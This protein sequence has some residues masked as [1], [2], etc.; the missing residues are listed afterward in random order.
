M[1][2]PIGYTLGPVF[3][4]TTH[5][6]PKPVMRLTTEQRWSK[7]EI[8]TLRKA[9]NAS[10]KKVDAGEK[11]LNTLTTK[12]TH[13]V[14]RDESGFIYDNRFCVICGVMLESL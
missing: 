13:P 9:V 8:D 12:C 3:D 11:K 2:K 7:K 1:S 14:F 10:Q 6:K 4:R 5:E